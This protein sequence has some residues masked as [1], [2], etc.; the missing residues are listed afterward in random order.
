[1]LTVSGNVGFGPLLTVRLSSFPSAM[2]DIFVYAK[3]GVPE[4]SS[5]STGGSMT[6]SV[7]LP[8][9]MFE[10]CPK[11]IP[12]GADEAIPKSVQVS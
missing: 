7:T 11:D 3:D 4:P 10:L 9:P 5:I 12:H 1:M 2:I 6:L 8:S